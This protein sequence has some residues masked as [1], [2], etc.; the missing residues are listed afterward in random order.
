[1]QMDIRDAAREAILVQDACNLSGVARTFDEIL[2]S[3]LWP[4]ARRLGMGTEWVNTHPVAVL[5]AAK[6]A[7]L[8]GLGD[9]AP[10]EAYQ[11][12]REL[13]DHGSSS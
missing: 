2:S 3:V 4:E 8:A 13:A 7:H 12:C 9:I 5:F 10:F 11:A 1:M 6:L